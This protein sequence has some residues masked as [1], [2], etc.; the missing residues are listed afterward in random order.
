[1]QAPMGMKIDLE[2]V[3]MLITVTILV[4]LGTLH[5]SKFYIV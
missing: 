2:F 4:L 1:M 3:H 5:L